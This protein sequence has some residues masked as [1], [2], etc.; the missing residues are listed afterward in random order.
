MKDSILLVEDD[1][2]IAIVITAALEAEGFHVDRCDS[3]AGRDCLLASKAYG[4]MLTDVMLTDGDGSRL[5]RPCARPF[6]A[7]R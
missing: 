3:I 6:R 5:C 7:C 2:S 1:S 4:L